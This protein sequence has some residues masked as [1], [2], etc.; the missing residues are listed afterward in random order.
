MG[1]S[2]FKDKKM[3]FLTLPATER[4][5]KAVRANCNKQ[6]RTY[7]NKNI[8]FLENLFYLTSLSNLKSFLDTFYKFFKDE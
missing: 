7:Q 4:N 3:L 1:V 8:V 2:V 5:K 6:I